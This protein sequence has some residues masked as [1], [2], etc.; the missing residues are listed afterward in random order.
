MRVI[1]VTVVKDDLEGLVRT[2][3]SL[4]KQDL[5]PDWWIVT[6]D[7]SEVTL[8]KAQEFHQKDIVQ[9]I[10]NDDGHGIY[11]AMNRAIQETKEDYWV[12]FLNAG[13]ELPFSNTFQKVREEI[14]KTSSRWVFGGHGLVSESGEILGYIDAPKVISAKNQLFAKRYVS[15]QSVVFKAQFLR[16][17]NG[18]DTTLRLAADWDLIVRASF[19]DSGLRIDETISF[20]HLGGLSTKLRQRGNIE[21]FHLRKKYLGWHATPKNYA[22]FLYRMNRNQLVLIVERFAPKIADHIRK[23]RFLIRQNGS[24]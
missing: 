15:H 18:F 8:K 3:K 19:V 16:E 2:S 1:V 4:L 24:K 20:F 22:W 7:N 5:K 12:W 6:P 11:F 21:L 13:D 17:L 14:T 9:K 23:L 10:L